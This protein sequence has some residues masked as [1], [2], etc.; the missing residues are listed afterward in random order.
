[1][2]ALYAGARLFALPS[3]YEGF[4]LPV[5]EA[6]AS[7]TPVVTSNR[8]SLPEITQGAALLGNPDDVSGLGELIAK[9][10]CDDA[11]RAEAKSMGLA[12]ARGYSWER[13]IRQT[14]S[15]YERIVS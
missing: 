8:S 5:L 2:P 15:V 4:G 9:G 6:M 10:L 7:G 11:W 3:S 14:V 1:V 12:V 13:C